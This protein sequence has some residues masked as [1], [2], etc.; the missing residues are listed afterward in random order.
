MNGFDLTGIGIGIVIVIAGVITV[1]G[2]RRRGSRRA[3]S[4]NRQ[5]VQKDPNLW[6]TGGEPSTTKQQALLWHRWRV[7]ATHMTK[8]EVSNEIRRRDG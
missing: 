6:K 3:P 5:T 2:G 4:A 7:D 8:A 1:V